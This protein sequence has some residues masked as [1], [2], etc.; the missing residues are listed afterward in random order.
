MTNEINE[1]T[2]SKYK[3]FVRGRIENIRDTDLFAFTSAMG[4]A[5][6]LV[7]IAPALVFG[8]VFYTSVTTTEEDPMNT[9][10]ALI[11]AISISIGLIVAG[12]MSSHTAI[13]LQGYGVEKNKIRFAWTLVVVY[14]SL[15]I[16]GLLAMKILGSHLEVVGIVAS[17]LTL[18]VY[19][20]RSSATRLTE[21]KEMRQDHQ[22]RIYKEAEEEKAHQRE[23]ERRRLEIEREKEL[24]KIEA[25]K[26][27]AIAKINAPK[28]VPSGTT[29]DTTELTPPEQKA[30]ILHYMEQNPDITMTQLAQDIGTSRR[31]LYRRL[32]E[33]K[34]EGLVKINGAGYKVNN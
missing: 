33:L 27:K 30:R 29:D 31:T 8:W 28:S 22:E 7:P 10:L 12:A 16:G 11:G 25:N 34:N 3:I 6:W 14:V 1:P 2:I 24:A 17:L 5:P 15:E 4:L 20:S 18:T 26:E 21:E 13:T 23:L 9:T 19:L 32:D